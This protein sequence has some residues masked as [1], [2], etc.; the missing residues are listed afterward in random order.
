MP[1]NATLEVLNGDMAGEALE[2]DRLGSF[3]L[4]RRKANDLALKDKA[5]SREHCRVDYDGEF[6]W[7]VDCDS[8]NG[9]YVNGQP[10]KKCMLYDGDVVVVGHTRLVFNGPKDDEDSAA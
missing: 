2:L 5:L 9:T 10:I 8:H 3:K 7:L 6:Y 4:G 1:R